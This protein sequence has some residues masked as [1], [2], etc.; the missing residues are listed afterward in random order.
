MIHITASFFT[1]NSIGS[2]VLHFWR[3]I[4]FTV[5]IHFE[6]GWYFIFFLSEGNDGNS[7]IFPITETFLES[8]IR[9]QVKETDHS[10]EG[11]NR[12]KFLLINLFFSYF[13]YFRSRTCFCW[14]RIPALVVSLEP[15]FASLWKEAMEASDTQCY[16]F[17]C[18]VQQR[19]EAWIPQSC[20]VQQQI[21]WWFQC[22]GVWFNPWCYIGK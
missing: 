10:L 13:F 17:L 12:N 14:E 9:K 16:F 2:H 7:Y 6:D 5:R 18:S 21:P 11:V 3:L 19:K 1:G 22:V 15:H 20:L 4:V 8:C